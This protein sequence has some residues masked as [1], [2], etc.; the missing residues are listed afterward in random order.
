MEHGESM[1]EIECIEK[2]RDIA[3]KVFGNTGVLEIKPIKV[4]FKENL[5]YPSSNN[6]IPDFEIQ[7][8]MKDG[9]ECT[10]FFEVK[11][12]GQP[13]Y[14]RMAINQ[15]QAILSQRK[16]VYGVVGAP[17]LTEETMIICRENNM[18]CIDMAGNCFLKFDN[19]Y[20][21]IQGNPNL[22]ST[23]R[24]LKSLFAQKSTRALRVLLC[25]PKKE[26]SVIELAEEA[27]ISLGQTSNLKRKLLDCEFIEECENKK[28][29]IR[30]PEVVLKKWAENYTYRRNKIT[31]YYSSDDVE[32]IEKRIADYGES[33]RIQYA[34]TLTSGVFLVTPSLRY[35]RAFVYIKNNVKDIA[36]SLGW[37]EVFSGPNIT[38]LEPYDEGIFYGL[39]NIN[40][41]KVVSDIQ[42][43]LDLQSYRERGE[44]SAQFLLEN[45]LKK[46]W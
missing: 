13:R 10:I 37:K 20:I 33:K 2:L 18:G 16:N 4:Q 43:Y 23:T 9:K 7:V 12:I 26:W 1:K 27:S 41:M 15:L 5:S 11:S 39:Q 25:N 32:T 46:Q 21:N 42:L 30:N 17:Y 35:K 36:G 3:T 8:K 6:L 24:P 19:V 44:E 22:Y 28:F 31:N 40:G 29:R 34:F 38:V 14:V 45:R